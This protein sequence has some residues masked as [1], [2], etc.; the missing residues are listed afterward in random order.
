MAFRTGDITNVQQSWHLLRQLSGVDGLHWVCIGDY[1]DLLSS[2]D[3]RGR[4]EHPQ[5]LFSGFRDAVNDCGLVDVPLTGY[6]FT[7]FRGRNPNI[8][9]E[10]HLDRAM[11][12]ASWHARFSNAS[13]LNL[14]VS[15]HSLILLDTNR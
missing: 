10:E 9:M 8:I 4:V 7:W 12:N 2:S 13:L 15:D 3:K 6:S 11:A 14:T 5:W 1:N